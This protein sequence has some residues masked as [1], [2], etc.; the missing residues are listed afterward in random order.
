MKNEL[1][2]QLTRDATAM[3][4]AWNIE[5]AESLAKKAIVTEPTRPEAFNILG[6][7]MEIRNDQ[8]QAQMYYRAALA[9]DPTYDPARKNLYRSTGVSN[10][11]TWDLGE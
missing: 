1:Y 10:S 5:E 11:V 7:V 6:I 8:S 3:L 4:K 9:F 2:D